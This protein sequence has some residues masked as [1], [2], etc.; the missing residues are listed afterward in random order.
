MGF[1]E[2]KGNFADSEAKNIREEEG[3]RRRDSLIQLIQDVVSEG[4]YQKLAV[5]AKVPVK[6]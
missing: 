2:T 5:R 4:L 1:L 6:S 3:G